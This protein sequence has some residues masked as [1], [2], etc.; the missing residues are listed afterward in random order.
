M[1]YFEGLGILKKADLLFIPGSDDPSYTA[2]KLY[3]Y[4]LTKKPI[5]GIFHQ[6]SSAISILRETNSAI[7]CTLNDR[8]EEVNEYFQKILMDILEGNYQNKTNW[9]E[10]EK[11]S[12]K[13]MT[14]RQVEV[15]EEVVRKKY[16]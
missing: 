15:F 14:R 4:I 13:E 8:I 7:V 12:A 10:F 3:P 9:M 2:S 16:E 6:K 11:Y 1:P 5:F